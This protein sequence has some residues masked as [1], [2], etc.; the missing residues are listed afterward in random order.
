MAKSTKPSSN[1]LKP[2]AS[3][4]VPGKPRRRPT[5]AEPWV[6]DLASG[7][8]ANIIKDIF[9]MRNGLGLSQEDL[10][11]RLGRGRD[12][13]SKAEGG[14][15][16][17]FAS[18]LLLLMATL[19]ALELEHPGVALLDHYMPRRVARPSLRAVPKTKE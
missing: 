13:L 16:R 10:A 14:R 3:S 18:D 12:W 2:V 6:D 9:R 7:I 17:L 8:D 19:R 1:P 5:L 4:R 15:R 11:E